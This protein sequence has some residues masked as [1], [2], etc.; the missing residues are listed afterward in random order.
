MMSCIDSDAASGL[1]VAHLEF[2]SSVS[3]FTT[4]GAD[5]AH[6][7]TASP[8][9]FENPAASL[10]DAFMRTCKQISIRAFVTCIKIATVAFGIL[11]KIAITA[12]G[13]LLDY[14]LYYYDLYSDALFSYTLV[15]NC[16][17]YYFSASVCILASSYV[18]TVAYL[19]YHMQV[20]SKF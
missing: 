4:M 1:A 6:H 9:G 16:H 3:P 17:W 7:I 11:K 18:I 15:H 14:G 10:I 20:I 12:L 5:Y 19:R 13:P 2:G 8:P